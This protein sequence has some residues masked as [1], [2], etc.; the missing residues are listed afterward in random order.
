LGYVNKVLQRSGII[1]RDRTEN[2][3][4]DTDVHTQTRKELEF[5][6]GLKGLSFE[7]FWHRIGAPVP[8]KSNGEIFDYESNIIDILENKS[9]YL[10]I[11][12]ATGLGITSLILYWIIWRA[13]RDDEWRNRQV[14]IV[15]GPNIDLA[16]K[17][18]KRIRRIFAD[19]HDITFDTKETYLEINGVQ[20]EAFPSY[21]VDAFRSL[22]N[23][24]V[25]Y[26]SEGDFFPL[27]QQVD[28]RHVSER[29]ILK[30]DPYLIIEST[31]NAPGGLMQTILNEE[32]SIY[33]KLKLD[34]TVG[35]GK[36]YS[37]D[38]MIESQK[39]S[40]SFEREY[41]LKFAGVI[42]NTFR[43][44]DI[45]RAQQL[46]Y[47]S[48]FINESSSRVIGIDPAW[49]S[50]SFGIVI[51]DFRDSKACVLLAEEHK[52]STSAEMLPYVLELMEKYKPVS[53]VYIDGSAVD[54]IRL[55]KQSIGEEADYQ[56][57]RKRYE[58]QK[59]SYEMNHTI[60]DVNFMKNNV[61]MLSHLRTIL[62]RGLLMIDGKRFPILINVLHNCSDDQGK[63]IKDFAGND[64]FDAL[65]LNMI[66]Y[67][68]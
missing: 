55:L 50:S 31:P 60:I 27:H 7:Q 42:G 34:Y 24:A 26:L 54:F 20:I 62:E 5:L 19:R 28:V 1:G 39:R 57:V 12:K 4:A 48:D 18:I 52:H 11:L 41:C 63:V 61:S 37:S 13:T 44:E 10:Y 35:L 43:T 16:V 58:S 64:C 38:R 23:P 47:D 3:D 32:D 15:V 46:E 49:G 6:S 30:S 59:I 9:K 22:E 21:H 65:R 36:I 51:T 17:L 66:G 67:D 14:C 45:E 8:I 25:V 68:L 56:A 53:K 2:P 40:P 33:H 29:Y